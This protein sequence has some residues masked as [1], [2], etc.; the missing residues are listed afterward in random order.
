[1]SIRRRIRRYQASSW[2]I[3]KRSCGIIVANPRESFDDAHRGEREEATD[4]VRIGRRSLLLMIRVVLRVLVSRRGTR[5]WMILAGSISHRDLHTVRQ[6]FSSG[7]SGI[8][9]RETARGLV[10]FP[11]L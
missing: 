7:T 3:R 4:R 6:N 10:S 11:S 5:R 8:R 9:L 1:M 2:R